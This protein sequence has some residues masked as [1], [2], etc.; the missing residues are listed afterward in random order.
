MVARHQIPAALFDALI[1][2][3]AL[4]C[5]GRR[6]DT[7]ESLHDY[8]ARVVGTVG[9]MMA[10]L[11]GVRSPDALA[12]ARGLGA[13]IQLSNI[14]RCV[15]ED[16]RMR[17][18]NLPRTRMLEAG[19]EP[20]A[21]LAKPTFSAA[22]AMMCRAWSMRPRRCTGVSMPAAQLPLACGPASTR[23]AFC[24]PRSATRSRGAVSIRSA[25]VPTSGRGASSGCCC[26]CCCCCCAR[27]DR[28]ARGLVSAPLGLADRIVRTRELFA[29]LEQRNHARGDEPAR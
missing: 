23:R 25:H 3:F 26:C 14:A 15:G 22:L 5:E 28:L 18:L 29:R 16:A 4:D 21:W 1:E 8:A 17:R 13:A 20:D 6:Y 7:T 11:M 12:R 2:G 9:A 24:M 19:V 10:L 27:R